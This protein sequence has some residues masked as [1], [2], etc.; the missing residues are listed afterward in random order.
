MLTEVII[1]NS[2]TSI[3]EG[4]FKNNPIA[5]VTLPA[6]FKGNPPVEAFDLVRFTYVDPINLE[7]EDYN[8]PNTKTTIT[9][10]KKDDNLK[11]TSK[12]D[13]ITGK[14]GTDI[15][16]GSKGDDVLKGN[17]GKDVLKGGKGKD[18]LDGSAG[19]DILIGG[20]HAD[21]FQISKGIDLVEGFSIKH[22]DRIA[23]D[24]TGKYKIIE[25]DYGVFIKASSKNQLLLEGVNYDDV[26]AAG[27]DLFVQPV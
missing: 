16:S 20:K 26:I 14:N 25:D 17:D 2:V 18:Y 23:L 19:G 5:E 11:G 8:S 7:P 21:V 24:S 12:N 10:T 1:P 6:H 27:V 22:G 4:A 15:L 3:G 9:G 13:L